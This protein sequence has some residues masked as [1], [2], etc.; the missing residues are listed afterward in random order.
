MKLKERHA[1]V[2]CI[3]HLYNYWRMNLSLP[4]YKTVMID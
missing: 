4:G 2:L 1:T 3:T